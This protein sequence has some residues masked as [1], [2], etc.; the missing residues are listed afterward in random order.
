MNK[1]LPIAT[2][3]LSPIEHLVVQCLCNGQSNLNISINTHLSVKLVENTIY[4]SSRVFGIASN[5]LVN[6]RVLLSLV[7]N[8]AFPNAASKS[9]TQAISNL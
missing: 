3:D 9:T 6:S 5:Q 8:A 1:S 4:R 7:Y 2:R